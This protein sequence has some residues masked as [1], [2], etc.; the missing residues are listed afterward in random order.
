MPV[1]AACTV[2][3]MR[4]V[5]STGLTQRSG[6]W[7]RPP[8]ARRRACGRASVRAW[9]LWI[10]VR[11]RPI[12]ATARNISATS[13]TRMPTIIQH[14]GRCDLGGQDH[15]SLPGSEGSARSARSASA[16]TER[17]AAGAGPC[18]WWAS[19]SSRS[20]ALHARRRPRARRGRGRGR[21]ARRARRAGRA[22]RRAVPAWS[23]ALAAGDRGADH[24]VA[25]QQRLVTGVGRRPVGTAV[26]GG[27]RPAADHLDVGPVDR[28]GEHVGGPDTPMNCSLSSAISSA[29]R[30]TAPT[31]RPAP[32][33]PRRRST[34]SA[35]AAQRAV[36]PPRRPARRPRTPRGRR[37]RRRAGVGA[38]RADQRQGQPR[39]R[40]RL[41][42][43]ARVGAVATRRPARR[44]RR[45]R[46][47][48]GGAPRRPG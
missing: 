46:P 22:R 9:A 24:D 1:R 30:R 44:R 14:V 27:R 20:R 48:S 10:V 33:R 16:G 25:E 26:V 8:A 13:S 31:A 28:E 19:S 42:E 23:A 2:W 4:T 43:R 32:A 37:R 17:N 36:R 11:D 35:R 6:F 40:S 7:T 34:A 5:S 38:T 39:C 3:Q 21:G 18:Q 47:R 41:G 45:C 29:R 15:R 12:S